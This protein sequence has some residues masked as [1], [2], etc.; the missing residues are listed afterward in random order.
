MIAWSSLSR[1]RAVSKLCRRGAW[2]MAAVGFAVIVYLNFFVINGGGDQGAP[3]LN[4]NQ[5]LMSTALAL[6]MAIPVFFFALI[7]FA[8]GTVLDYMSA[9]KH[10]EEASDES[11]EGVEI[12][13]LPQM[14]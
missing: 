10:I 9:E 14:R 4:L 6:L 8:V 2:F 7:L 1:M 3:G 13:S 5:L 11:D 12:T